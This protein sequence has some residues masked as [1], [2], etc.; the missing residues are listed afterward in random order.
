NCRTLTVSSPHRL[1]QISLFRFCR[2]SRRWSTTL[3]VHDYERQLGHP[4]KTIRFLF[5]SDAWSRRS[6]Q[7]DVSGEARTNR[8]TNSRDFVFRLKRFDTKTLVTRQ[9]VKDV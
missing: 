8:R 4:A 5:E 1:K 2:K 3:H 7:S 9:L 6:R